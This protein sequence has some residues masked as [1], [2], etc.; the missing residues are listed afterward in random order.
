MSTF[1]DL[2]YIN[3]SHNQLTGAVP[4]FLFHKSHSDDK[5]IAD[6]SS[7]RFQG[8]L[9]GELESFS[10]LSLQVS[11]NRI[12]GIDERLCFVEGWN[13]NDVGQ[14]ECDAI[15]CPAGTWNH[16]GRMSSEDTPCLPCRKATYMGSTKCHHS[17]SFRA[18]PSLWTA[19]VA[20][21]FLLMT[22]L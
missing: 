20:G 4:P 12:S 17:G 8:T 16:I 2:V 21:I 5:L 22:L 18:A 7:N 15:L 11:G 19:A 6:L 1:E 9:P 14:F 13:D 10:H 3:L